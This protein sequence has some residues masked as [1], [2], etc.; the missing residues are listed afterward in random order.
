[1]ER[2]TKLLDGKTQYS[3]EVRAHTDLFINLV[4]FQMNSHTQYEMSQ[5][6]SAKRQMKGSTGFPAFLQ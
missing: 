3:Q 6:S 1:M 2:Q 5:D 4:G